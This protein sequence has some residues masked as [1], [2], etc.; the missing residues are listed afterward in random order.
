MG[1]TFYQIILFTMADGDPELA[2]DL[3][4][5]CLRQL[6]SGTVMATA[7]D[8]TRCGILPFGRPACIMFSTGSAAQPGIP[9]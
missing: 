8:Q 1:P 9:W 2:N 7:L 6:S 3:Y 4:N 5:I